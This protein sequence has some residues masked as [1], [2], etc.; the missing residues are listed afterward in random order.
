MTPIAVPFDQ[1]IQIVTVWS[2]GLKG[3]FVKQALDSA[4]HATLVR[5]ALRAD[6]PAHFAVPAATKSN[7]GRA[8]NSCGDQP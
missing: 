4:A 3:L 8:C 2:V 6:R 1:V 5:L 7:D